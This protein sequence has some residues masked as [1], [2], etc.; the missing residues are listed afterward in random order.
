MGNRRQPSGVNAI[1]R[2]GRDLRLLLR[3]RKQALCNS[4]RF[5]SPT[6]RRVGLGLFVGALGLF[7][8]VFWA[9]ASL[10][11]AAHGQSPEAQAALI[12]QTHLW[13][14]LFLLAGGVPFVSGVLLAPSD[15]ALLLA[16]APSSPAALVAA[17]LID[18]VVVASSQFV[19]LGV[20]LLFACAWALH[21]PFWAGPIVLFLVVLEITVPAL[22]VALLLLGFARAFGVRRVKGAVAMANALLAVA[23]CLLS[24]Q[25]ISRQS[26]HGISVATVAASAR[27]AAQAQQPTVE[28]LLPSA[29][30]ARSLFALANADGAEA[31]KNLTL[32][33]AT[34]AALIAACIVLGRRVLVGDLLLSDTNARSGKNGWE[35]LIERL[36]FVSPP[37]RGL[38]AK[39]ARYVSRDLVLWSQIGTPLILFFVP[40]II[41]AQISS[42]TSSGSSTSDL[43]LLCA[44]VTLTIAYMET[45]ILGLSALGL[46]G[47]GFWLVLSA[48]VSPG[49]LLRA[50]WTGAFV[51]SL[52]F[53]VPLWI[54][55]GLVY[56]AGLPLLV[57]G[58]AVLV[59]ACAALCGLAVGISG[60]FPR[61]VY[62]NPAHRASVSALVWGFVF[63]SGYVLFGGAFLGLSWFGAAQW[64]EQ[65]TT[66]WAIGVACFVVL[67]LAA[68]FV[69]LLLARK[70]L[71]IL[72][73][74]TS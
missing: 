37:L 45:S 30:A 3:V 58:T 50:K 40:F 38:L 2:F 26:S 63:A 72:A 54:I 56:A 67:S 49:L 28:A 32:L 15:E 66:F 64:P 60:I 53:C 48:P 74:E 12:E 7:V 19:V 55:A 21:I 11:R 36:P 20:P 34:C 71:E 24:V 51:A 57:I 22:L 43:L 8:C 62:D 14:F 18:A 42:G 44:G 39:D 4:A 47:R 61:F 1:R 52:V 27:A 35:T 33:T 46:E 69:P 59:V 9:F 17:R 73:W 70:R 6:A 16:N 31:A 5:S 10:L 23:L 65:R 13:V 68:L 25:A 41:G 29:W